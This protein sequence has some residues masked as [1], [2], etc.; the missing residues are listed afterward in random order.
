[1]RQPLH[2]EGMIQYPNNKSITYF[3]LLYHK[4][5]IFLMISV[6]QGTDI[7]E[8]RVTKRS[9]TEVKV[10]KSSAHAPLDRLKYVSY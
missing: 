3:A 7:I 6:L 4:T 9:K 1:V 5:I 10:S 8:K 2:D